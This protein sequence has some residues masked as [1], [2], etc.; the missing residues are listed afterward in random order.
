HAALGYGTI[1]GWFYVEPPADASA[2]LLD[3]LVVL[4]QAF[5]MGAF[6]LISALF[7]PGSYDR[8]GAGRFLT[9]RLL[10]LG[11]PLVFWLLVLRPLVTVDRFA[12]ER[13]AAAQQGV[14]LPYWQFSLHSINPGPMWFVGVLLVFSAL[15]VLWR[16]RS[17]DGPHAAGSVPVAERAPGAGV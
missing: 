15:Y 9:D 2:V 4:D 13:A 3:V 5:F 8:K 12:R 10:R 6:F 1:P 11:V 7:V 14:D 17:G 16:Q